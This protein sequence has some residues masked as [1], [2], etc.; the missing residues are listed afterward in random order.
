A[1]LMPPVARVVA[2]LVVRV[3]GLVTMSFACVSGESRFVSC[4]D[5][6]PV[7]SRSARGFASAA[8]QA[9]ECLAR[10]INGRGIPPWPSSTKY[11]SQNH[12]NAL[13]NHSGHRGD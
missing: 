9:A 8:Q 5:A 7:R 10:F 11:K 1:L 13:K 6:A 12:E 3:A 4:F 2:G